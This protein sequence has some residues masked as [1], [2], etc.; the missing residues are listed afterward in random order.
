[1]VAAPGVTLA[2]AIVTVSLLGVT[3]PA[4]GATI[5]GGPVLA[6]RLS[7]VW[8]AIVGARAR[9][10]DP[11]EAGALGGPAKADNRRTH[12]PGGTSTSGLG[13]SVARGVRAWAASSA[14]SAIA[15]TAAAAVIAG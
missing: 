11:N 5:S 7:A 1:T 13:E 4:A 10:A 8:E 9:A 6:G 14:P 15:S 12:L 2:L 3:L